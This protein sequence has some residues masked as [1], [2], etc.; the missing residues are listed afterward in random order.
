MTWRKRRGSGIGPGE[1]GSGY[2]LE[3]TGRVRGITWGVGGSTL[4]FFFR[5][6]LLVRGQIVNASCHL[7]RPEH[8]A[9]NFITERKRRMTG[10]AIDPGWTSIYSSSSHCRHKICG[11]VSSVPDPY[12]VA[13]ITSLWRE[14]L[15][16]ELLILLKK[17]NVFI[18]QNSSY[19]LITGMF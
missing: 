3:R 19:F 2:H 16:C 6:C 5:L 17:A 7:Q 1:W 12:C 18:F 9:H 10:D 8:T 4:R 11:S 14:R 15:T 13:F